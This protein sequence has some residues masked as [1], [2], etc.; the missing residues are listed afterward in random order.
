M[1]YDGDQHITAMTAGGHGLGF[2][3]PVAMHTMGGIAA[4]QRWISPPVV[5]GEA[6]RHRAAAVLQHCYHWLES[7]VPL[8]PESVELIPAL[9]TAVQ[10]YEAQQ[11]AACLAQANAVVQTVRQL[12]FTVPALPPL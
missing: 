4:Q 3:I 10:Q 1:T 5:D 9:V 12:R 7:A 2:A 11:Y 6:I 8:V